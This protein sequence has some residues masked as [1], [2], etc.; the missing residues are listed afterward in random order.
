MNDALKSLEA[1]L[2]N[3]EE[4]LRLIAE[5]KS[6]YIEAT[7][8]PLDLV[9]NEQRLMAERE[10]LLA[11]VAKL[12]PAAPDSAGTETASSPAHDAGEEERRQQLAI[13]RHNLN[14]LELQR[15]RYG[16]R[17]PLDLINEI[18]LVQERI[19]ELEEEIAQLGSAEL[20]QGAA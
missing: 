1:Q 17:V 12:S 10:R 2:T 3:V 5:R 14:K 15:A 7:S 19:G 20:G 8:I 11:E 16:I 9:K 4:S 18:K 13:Q 6:E